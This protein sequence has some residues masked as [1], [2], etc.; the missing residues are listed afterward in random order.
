MKF[1]TTH[2]ADIDPLDSLDLSKRVG[3][4]L[5][6]ESAAALG[7]DYWIECE[8]AGNKVK[9]VIKQFAILANND[10]TGE[11]SETGV[12]LREVRIYGH[13]EFNQQNI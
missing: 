2:F 4:S 1:L 11:Y 5:C 12:G 10:E 13:G 3:W 7:D 6:Y 9:P 8:M